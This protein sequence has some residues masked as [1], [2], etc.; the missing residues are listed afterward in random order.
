[1]YKES[2]DGPHRPGKASDDDVIKS[3]SLPP[4]PPSTALVSN[5]HQRKEIQTKWLEN[6]ADIY[7]LWDSSVGAKT[8]HIAFLRAM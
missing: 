5:C 1:M 8:T 6:A 3:C 7:L 4:P 2:E